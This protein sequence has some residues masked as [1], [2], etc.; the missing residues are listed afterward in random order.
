[1]FLE[2]L[3]VG[4]TALLLSWETFPG[5]EGFDI[6][7]LLFLLQLLKALEPLRASRGQDHKGFLPEKGPQQGKNGM[8]AAP[9]L[10]QRV[11][12]ARARAEGAQLLV[13]GRGF[14][15]ATAGPGWYGKVIDNTPDLQYTTDADGY[16]HMPRNPFADGP[17]V[18]TYG[19]HPSFILMTLGN[20]FGG[21]DAVLSHWVDMLI[22][23]DPRRLYSSASSAQTTPNRQFTE[24][25]PRGIHGPGTDA[26]FAAAI[27][28]NVI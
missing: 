12:A 19:N 24:S 11:V 8:L 25:G 15:G 6:N 7:R 5:K 18:H 9:H 3:K 14:A 26:D 10:G 27:A 17:I 16:A 23:R 4:R 13:D 22:Q 20:E 2:E 21:P 28:N 1:M